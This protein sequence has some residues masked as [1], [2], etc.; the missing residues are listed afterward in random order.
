MA[1]YALRRLQPDALLAEPLGGEDD[2][3][4]NDTVP[5]DLAVVVD[6]VD[7]QVQRVDALPQAPVDP[8]P[9][10]GR[11]QARHEVERKDLLLAAV[12]AVDVERDAHVHQVALGGALPSLE[13]PLG[14][15]VDPVHEEAE[16]AARRAVGME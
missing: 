12:I 1:P 8:V 7:E 9:L 13:V 3:F 11:D 5:N 10:L 16:L 14:Q 15:G 6:V 2:L 4:G